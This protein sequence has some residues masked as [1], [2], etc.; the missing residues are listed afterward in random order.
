MMNN[1]KLA[2]TIRTINKSNSAFKKLE[3]LFDIQ[4]MNRTSKR[5]KEDEVIK[6]VS[7]SEFVIAGTEP[8]NENVLKSTK[9]LK[10]ISRIGVGLDNIDLKTASDKNI[11]ICN[12]PNAPTQAV[13]EHTITLILAICK[14]IVAYNNLK[15]SGTSLSPIPGQLLSGRNIGIIGLG[16]IGH[17]VGKL[18][19]AFGCEIG[20][21]DPFI[22]DKE[23]HNGWIN[24]SS[25]NE[26]LEKSDIITLHMPPKDDNSPILDKKS[27]EH[28]KKG[29]ILINTA[30]SSLIDEKALLNA[31]NKEIIS[32]AGLDVYD[33]IIEDQIQNYPQII[34]TP[35]VASNTKESR[36]EM[37]REAIENLINAFKGIN[38]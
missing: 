10:V 27:F 3:E 23:I 12:T 13:A 24:Y 32:G 8:F 38:P 31:I 4:Y 35:H 7:N 25:I 26:L 21:Y 1:P 2:I 34:L 18:L 6:A 16:R 29:S 19:S 22:K 9:C 14:N 11:L 15:K 36:E 17:T 30:R 5:L 20:Y 28:F 33:S 37:E